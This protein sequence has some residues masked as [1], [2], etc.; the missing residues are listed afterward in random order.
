MQGKRRQVEGNTRS[1]L[2]VEFDSA[3]EDAL[4]TQRHVAAWLEKSEGWC[5]LRRTA[6]GG[7][8]YLKLGRSVRYRKRDVLAW[9]NDVAIAATSTSQY[10]APAAARLEQATTIPDLQN[11]PGGDKSMPS[12]VE[13]HAAPSSSECGGAATKRATTPP[14]WGANDAGAADAGVLERSS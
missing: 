12:A 10:P 14:R 1:T 3:P 7:P 5:E 8:P 2:R 6:G 4:L 9:L 11:K 13:L